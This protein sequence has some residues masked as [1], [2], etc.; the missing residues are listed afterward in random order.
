MSNELQ[1]HEKFINAQKSIVVPKGNWNEFGKYSYRSC[2]D[3]LAAAKPVLS[4][5]GLFVT[6]TD[7]VVLVGDRHYIESTAKVSDGNQ[8]IEARAFARESLVKKGMD[9]SQITGTASSYARKFALS[10]LLGLDDGKEPVSTDDDTGLSKEQAI[11]LLRTRLK[12]MKKNEAG[13]LDYLSKKYETN[14]KFLEDLNSVQF[15]H[16]MSF[17]GAKK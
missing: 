4:S 3:I 9:E 6:V 15:E 12:E 1:F 11:E 14:L 10:G 2:E 7:S 17:L 8:W 16:A 5:Y 13:L